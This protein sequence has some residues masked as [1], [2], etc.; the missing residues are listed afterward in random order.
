MTV[1]IAPVAEELVVDVSSDAAP[2]VEPVAEVGIRPS[3][4]SGSR[5]EA[6][7]RFAAVPAGA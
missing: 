5:S 3:V 7:A 1:V 4:E 6:P 2:L